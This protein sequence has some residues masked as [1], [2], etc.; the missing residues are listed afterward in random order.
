MDDLDEAILGP[1][2]VAAWLA[3]C[4]A[5]AMLS[6]CIVELSDVRP[7]RRLQA[8]PPATVLTEGSRSARRRECRRPEPP[9]CP[10]TAPIPER[11]D[12][13]GRSEPAQRL[14]VVRSHRRRSLDLDSSDQIAARLQHDVDL[15][16]ILV[17]IMGEGRALGAP[18]RDRR[19]AHPRDPSF[20]LDLGQARG[21]ESRKLKPIGA[22][23]PCRST[24]LY[25]SRERCLARKGVEL[26]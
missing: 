9:D 8:G 22:R 14:E 25:R 3:A 13:R 21:F 16:L 24:G 11:S 20:L 23:A 19:S 15:D 6:A 4:S 17:A 18:G 10:R 26:A 2:D 5:W 1:E 12:R 7:C